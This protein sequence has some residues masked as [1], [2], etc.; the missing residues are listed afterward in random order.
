MTLTPN[1]ALF[2]EDVGT[3]YANTKKKRLE[4]FNEQADVFVDRVKQEVASVVGG[5]LFDGPPQDPSAKDVHDPRGGGDAR[6]P[7]AGDLGDV[8]LDPRK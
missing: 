4:E 3:I 2:G 8:E 6:F 7:D 5:S 1:A